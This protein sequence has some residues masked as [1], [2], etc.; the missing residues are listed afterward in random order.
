MNLFSLKASCPFPWILSHCP[1]TKGYGTWDTC[2]TPYRMRPPGNP[3]LAKA[4]GGSRRGRPGNE[5][6]YTMNLTE[7]R[8]IL[9]KP[10]SASFTDAISQAALQYGYEHGDCRII[11]VKAYNDYGDGIITAFG[12]NIKTGRC[13]VSMTSFGDGTDREG[14]ESLGT[15]V[16]CAM[17]RSG[18]AFVW[19][20]E[21]LRYA[22]TVAT[23]FHEDSM[24]EGVRQ[25]LAY[26]TPGAIAI[27][28]SRK[29]AIARLKKLVEG[30]VRE[31]YRERHG[32]LDWDYWKRRNAMWTAAEKDAQTLAGLDD[33][34]FCTHLRKTF[35][36]AHIE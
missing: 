13:F 22:H 11:P 15:F 21:R 2:W 34:A 5:T 8:T 4:Q 9:E 14:S 24:K 33:R 19:R 16:G 17:T 6:I 35:N 18:Y 29:A 25:L 28:T 10:F 32:G 12:H 27:R 20:E 1:R 23:T 3:L 36:N 7:I 31:E 26:I 30:P